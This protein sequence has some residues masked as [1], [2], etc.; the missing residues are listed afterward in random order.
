MADYRNVKV[1]SV[2]NVQKK[3][4]DFT[5]KGNDKWKY[6]LFRLYYYYLLCPMNY[7]KKVCM[8]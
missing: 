8:Y 7:R 1:L 6:T 5:I 2:K 4:F 3:G